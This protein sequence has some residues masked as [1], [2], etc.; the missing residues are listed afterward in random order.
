MDDKVVE[1]LKADGWVYEDGYYRKRLAGQAPSGTISNG[2]RTVSLKVDGRWLENWD[3]GLMKV[4]SDVDLRN[5]SDPAKA[6]IDVTNP[7]RFLSI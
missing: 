2:A 1:Y 4:K 6:V 5:Y 7:K 3:M